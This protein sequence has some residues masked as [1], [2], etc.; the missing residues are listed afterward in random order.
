[1][2]TVVEDEAERCRPLK[3]F[4]KGAGVAYAAEPWFGNTEK[5]VLLRSILQEKKSQMTTA[6]REKR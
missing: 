1:M 6:S 2:L 4:G 5:L 3:C